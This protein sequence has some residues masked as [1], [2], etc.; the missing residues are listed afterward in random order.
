MRLTAEGQV[1][2]LEANAN[3][4]LS[5]HEDLARSAAAGGDDYATLLERILQL[6]INYRAAWRAT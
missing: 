6:G 5:A 3:P 1:Y 4:C 2:V